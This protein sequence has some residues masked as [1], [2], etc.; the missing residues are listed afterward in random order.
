MQPPETIQHLGGKFEDNLLA[1]GLQHEPE[2]CKVEC[3]YLL[4]SAVSQMNMLK[5]VGVGSNGSWL[6]EDVSAYKLGYQRNETQS[7]QK[8]KVIFLS[9]LKLIFW[10]SICVL[11]SLDP[12]K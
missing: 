4:H 11:E 1:V 9:D 12:G 5:F 6:L 8:L 2:R 7:N 3:N 10:F